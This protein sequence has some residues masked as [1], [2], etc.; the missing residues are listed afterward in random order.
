MPIASAEMPEFHLPRVRVHAPKKVKK[1]SSGTEAKEGDAQQGSDTSTGQFQRVPSGKRA[2][3]RSSFAFNTGGTFPGITDSMEI[4][5]EVTSQ[6]QS[7][8]FTFEQQLQPSDSEA[9]TLDRGNSGQSEGIPVDVP[10]ISGAKPGRSAFRRRSDRTSDASQDDRLERTVR[11]SQDSDG[12]DGA[13]QATPRTA[14]LLARYHRKPATRNF[15]MQVLRL[16]CF[17]ELLRSRVLVTGW[18]WRFVV[19]G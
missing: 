12:G 2:P 17:C 16:F 11:F 19:G 18:S 1:D 13:T 3:R 7:G 14:Q 8:V 10:T 6:N 4:G 9:Y 5:V 15:A